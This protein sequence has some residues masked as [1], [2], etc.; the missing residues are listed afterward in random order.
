M[1]AALVFGLGFLSCGV[2]VKLVI[3]LMLFK[4]LMEDMRGNK[5]SE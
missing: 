1:A 4:L 3:D 2:L 5:D